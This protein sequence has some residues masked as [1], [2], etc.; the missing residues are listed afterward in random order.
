[1][2]KNLTKRALAEM[3]SVSERYVSEVENGSRFP[4]LRYCLKSGEL[5]GANPMWVK[6]KWAKEAV[7]RFS[8][9]LLK[10]LHLER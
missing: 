2:H 8:E 6:T 7:N 9:R 3:F 5:Y 1:M 4:S 10:R